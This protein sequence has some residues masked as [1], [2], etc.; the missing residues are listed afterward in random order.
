MAISLPGSNTS[1]DFA[2]PQQYA[3]H[4]RLTPEVKEAL[5]KAQQQGQQASL[6]LTG[7]ATD[8]VSTLRSQTARL[9]AQDNS[10]SKHNFCCRHSMLVDTALFLVLP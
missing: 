7:H 1:Y 8:N 2:N 6:Q 9:T 4:L 10:Q 3:V 5:L